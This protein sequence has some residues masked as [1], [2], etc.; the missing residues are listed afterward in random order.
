MAYD[1]FW[2]ILK[3][4]WTA[5]LGI[6]WKSTGQLDESFFENRL[7]IKTKNLLRIDWT[8]KVHFIYVLKVVLKYFFQSQWLNE[9]HLSTSNF[10]NEN[11]LFLLIQL[12]KYS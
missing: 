12:I 10:Y 6:H 9:K 4:N 3:I 8:N 11:K 1:K 2:D 5:R 7:D